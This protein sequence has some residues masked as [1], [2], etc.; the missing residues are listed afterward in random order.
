MID[1]PYK[2]GWQG[3]ELYIEVHAPLQG[4]DDESRF[5]LTNITR[6]LVSATQDRT[7]AIDWARAEK[8]FI[9]A[10]GV[11]EPVVLGNQ[12]AQTAEP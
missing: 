10:S 6:L 2:M 7:V 11:P 12:V 4:Q 5:S 9:R 8:A 3:S 1:Q